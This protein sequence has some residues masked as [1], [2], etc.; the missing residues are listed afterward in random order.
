MTRLRF[1]ATIGLLTLL[2]HATATA[3]DIEELK[4]AQ[5][6]FQPLPQDIATSDSPIGPERVGLGRVLFFDPR[7]TI[8]G[9]LSCSSCHQPAR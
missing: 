7:L 3:T 8:D 1:C 4:R 5:D 6:L 2:P 9:N